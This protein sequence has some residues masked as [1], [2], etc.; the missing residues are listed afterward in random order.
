MLNPW[1]LVFAL[2]A[3]GC[4]DDDD[5]NGTA[6][7][8]QVPVDGDETIDIGDDELSDE[9]LD[10]MEITLQDEYR[11]LEV[12][13]AVIEDFG[14]VQPFVNIR[15]AEAR[16]AA[17]I[18]ALYEARDLEVPA[19]DWSPDNVPR[20]DSVGE[21]CE[22]GVEGEIENIALYDEALALDLPDDVRDVFEA[23]RRASL[24]SHLPAFEACATREG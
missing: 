10:A 4:G 7:E 19:S 11:A 3:V 15:E 8:I 20:Y 1:L 6:D 16:H 13:A 17:A 18:E 14:P 12:Y 9:V 21:A 22:A 2:V 24:D 5:E 23:L